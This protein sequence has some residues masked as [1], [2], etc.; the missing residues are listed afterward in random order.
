MRVWGAE[1]RTT[2]TRTAVEYPPPTTTTT[3]ATSGPA[4][5]GE[6]LEEFD[7]RKVRRM[8]IGHY[9]MRHEIRPSTISV[10]RLWHT[11]EER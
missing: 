5:I 10:L 3:T 11:R 9:E 4:R 8:L 1:K 6:R 7:P 2:R